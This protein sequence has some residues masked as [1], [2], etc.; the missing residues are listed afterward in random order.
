MSSP[1]S[2]ELS[3]NDDRVQEATTSYGLHMSD[4]P[5]Y[6]QIAPKNYKTLEVH[7]FAKNVENSLTSTSPRT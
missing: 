2:P 6:Y 3:E 7:E 1:R 4:E 5:D